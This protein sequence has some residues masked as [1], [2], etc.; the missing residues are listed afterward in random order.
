[1]PPEQA[2]AC[3]RPRGR[4]SGAEIGQ[5]RSRLA[6]LEAADGPPTPEHYQFAVG[7]FSNAA[8]DRQAGRILSRW[9]NQGFLGDAGLGPDRRAQRGA[10]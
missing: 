6:R 7:K 9:I 1:L 10:A 3:G 4:Q 2:C 8:D 5:A